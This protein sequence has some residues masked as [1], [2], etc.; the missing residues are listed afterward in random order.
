MLAVAALAFHANAAIDILFLRHGETT[1]NRAKI[2]QGSVPYTDLTAKGVRMAEETAKGMAA[3]GISFGRIYTSPYLRA[4]HTAEVIAAG[5]CGPAPVPDVRIRE[6]CFGRYDGVR[7][8]KGAYPDE[9]LRIFFEEQPDRYVPQGEGAETIQA[10]GARIRDF[11]E[12]EVR[13]LD[14]KVDRILCVAHSLVLKAL[15][16]ELSGDSA[17]VAAKKALQRNCCVHMVRYENG[18]FTLGET[19]R[20]FYRSEDFDGTPG[21]KMVAHRGAG[22]LTMPEASLPAYSN[23]VA[24]AN[25]IVKLDLQRTKDG[26]IVMGHDVT[27]KRNMGWP[28]RIDSLTY[29]EIFEKGRFLEDGKPGNERIVRLDQALEIVKPVPEFWIDFKDSKGFSPEFGEAAVA[30]IRK[31]GIDP[32][33]VMVATF[34]RDALAYFR[35]NHPEFRRVG[36]FSFKRAADGNQEIMQK[37]LEFRDEY[38]LFGL[39]MPVQHLQTQP[40]DIAFLK[41]KGLWISLWFVQDS[42]KAA[43]YRSSG[44]D[45]FVTDHVS[46]ARAVTDVPLC[47]EWHV[48]GDGFKGE[49][50]L[51]GTLAAAHLGKRWTEHDFQTTMDLEQ[52]EA[53]VQEWKY[54]G[55]AVWTRT[56]TLT[57]ED[58]AHPMELFLERVMWQSEAFWD[59]EALGSCDSLATPHVYAVPAKLLTPGRHELKLEIDNSCRYNFSRC[60]HSYG[61]S[62]QAVWN[63]VLGRIELR[64]SHPL[65]D[66]RVFAS[67]DGKLRVEVPEGFAAVRDSVT[68]D[69]LSIKSIAETPSPYRAGFKMLTLKLKDS[70]VPWSE[71]HPQLYT[72]LL[73]D[74]KAGFARRIRFGFRTAGTQGHLL[75]LNGT[76]IFTRGN[77][78]NANFAKDGIPWMDKASWTRMIRTLRDEDGVNAIRFHTW[79]PPAA[80]FEAADDL[81]VILQPEAGVWTDGWMTHADEVGNGKPVDGFVLRELKAIAD[82]YGNSPSFFSLSIGNELGTSNFETMGKWV[83]E[84]RKYDPRMLCYA[85]S[86]RKLTDADDFSLSHVVPGKGL[87]REKLLAHTDWDYEDIY[88]TAR[89]PTVAHEIGQW[90]VYPIWDELFAPF[91]GTMRPWNLTRH[92]DTAAK[93]NALRFQREYHDASAK[94]NRLIYKE[95]VESFLRTPSCAGLQ[96]LEV[97]DYTGQAEALVGWRDPFYALKT[98]FK[99]MEPFSTVW[100]PVCFLARFPRFTYTVGETFRAELEIRNLTEKPLAAGVKFR[101]EL[102]GRKGTLKLPESIAPGEV[103]KVG[104]VECPLTEEMV[105]CRQTLRFGRNSWNFWVYPREERCAVPDGV[106]E[107]GDLATMRAAIA[108]GKTVLYSGPSFKSAKGQFKS[109]YWSARWFPVANTTAAALGTWFDVKHPS[110]A[111]FVTDDFTDWQWYSLA[112]GG[113]VHA[114]KGM[115]ESFRPVALS[116]NDFHFSDFTATMFEVLV[117]KGRLFVCGYDLT[118]DTPEAKRLRASVCAYLGRDPAPGTVSMPESWLA[119]EFEAPNAP[120]LSGAVYDVTTNWTGRTFKMELRGAPPTTGNVRID[121]HQPLNGLTSGRGLIEGRVFEVPFTSKKGAT[122]HVSLPVIREDFLDGHVDIEVNVMTGP[123]LAIDRIRIIPKGED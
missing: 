16:R 79:C 72:L 15:V 56:V 43:R 102:A 89:I 65:R 19:G 18:R 94:L 90:P 25:D 57:K 110:L 99:G 34:T 88:S 115:P 55:K 93:K 106:V 122:T 2:L 10:V 78:E 23:A 74:E 68:V 83:A 5:G 73:K 47:G 77:V 1:W 123:A 44:A 7:Y 105:K 4:R 84:H 51:P 29:A 95:E 104:T 98:G 62:M 67:A 50:K 58:C 109:V 120:D 103:T 8:G 97:Q 53:L 6:M 80:A 60:A 17:P 82:A 116:V 13:P 108:E 69:D 42:D 81:G 48:E 30:A 87:A 46:E 111:G 63:G 118:K 11:L 49:A 114:L 22:D 86:A 37:A 31:A 76:G 27:L 40:E 54:E 9:N 24:M 39:N 91:T 61:P 33:R 96:L 36:H 14:G 28:A 12:N 71:F 59:G 52:S 121:F 75:T 41:S 101:Y 66:A 119:A 107:T 26:V 3:A 35:D 92:R 113:I 70:P 117:G 20:I 32:S 112:Q 64:R 45:A 21:P 85:S 38:G 100:G